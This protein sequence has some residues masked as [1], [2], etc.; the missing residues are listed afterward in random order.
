MTEPLM[1]ETSALVAILLEEPGWKPLAEQVVAANAFTTC[2]N[3]F[4]ASL[5]IVRE[6]AVMPGAAYGI[7]LEAAA[8]L[9][10]EVTDYPA[11][12]LPFAVSA[13]EAFGS[14]RHGLNIGDCLSYGAAR[15]AGARLLYV[16]EDFAR[17]DVNDPL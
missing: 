15:C 11:R 7:V 6:R 16:D 9:D 2:V 4:E 1:V 12:A 8:R 13:R 14:G 5:A 17:T 3:V 10:V